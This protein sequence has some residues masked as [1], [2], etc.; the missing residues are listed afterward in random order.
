MM[1]IGQRFTTEGDYTSDMI[2]RLKLPL[3]KDLNNLQLS[4]LLN[5]AKLDKWAIQES[6]IN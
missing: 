2:K 4:L 3:D 5:L 6:G 1:I